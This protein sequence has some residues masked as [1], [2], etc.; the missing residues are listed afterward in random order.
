MT[1]GKWTSFF[2]VAILNGSTKR[3]WPITNPCPQARAWGVCWTCGWRRMHKHNLAMSSFCL[4][5]G[6]TMGPWTQ[7]DNWKIK[8][9]KN[10]SWKA[11]LSPEGSSILLLLLFFFLFFFPFKGK[12][13]SMTVD[14]FVCYINNLDWFLGLSWCPCGC[15]LPI[16]STQRQFCVSCANYVDTYIWKHILPSLVLCAMCW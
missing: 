5:R 14:Y 8:I 12:V 9:K 13:R 10:P 6:T 15:S 1:K 7:H 4:L 16:L 2:E 11:L 3:R